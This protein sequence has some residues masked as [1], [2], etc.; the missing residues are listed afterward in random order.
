MAVTKKQIRLH[1]AGHVVVVVCVDDFWQSAMQNDLQKKISINF[2]LPTW[3]ACHVLPHHKQLGK[4][5]RSNTYH[6]FELCARTPKTFELA[7]L[8]RKQQQNYGPLLLKN[9]VASSC[10]LFKK[11]LL[12]QRHPTAFLSQR[13]TIRLYLLL[14]LNVVLM[15]SNLKEFDFV[16]QYSSNF[17]SWSFHLWSVVSL[18]T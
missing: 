10:S 15:K 17:G 6:H 1:F 14:L 18:V 13:G 2:K 11:Y 3:W 12:F 16:M 5:S 4:A 9:A 8:S 7:V